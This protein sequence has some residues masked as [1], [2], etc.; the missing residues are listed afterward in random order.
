[1]NKKSGC[2]FLHLRIGLYFALFVLKDKIR[3]IILNNLMR[4]CNIALTNATRKRCKLVVTKYI[5]KIK[6][7]M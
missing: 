7:Q 6:I 1:M 4:K 5:C 3:T 2:A